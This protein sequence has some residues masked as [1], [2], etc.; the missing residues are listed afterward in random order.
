M[1][2]LANLSVVCIHGHWSLV[3]KVKNC[4]VHI[5]NLVQR[6]SVGSS[7][8]GVGANRSHKFLQ[9]SGD[10]LF[11]KCHDLQARCAILERAGDF[12]QGTGVGP[13]IF[14][15]IR[16]H[17]RTD[18]YT[19]NDRSEHSCPVRNCGTAMWCAHEDYAEC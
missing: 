12:L 1:G 6:A 5:N 9:G 18:K 11:I 8:W 19:V 2:E 15:K 7:S 17:T 10:F 16:T 4:G 13:K 3:R 14:Q